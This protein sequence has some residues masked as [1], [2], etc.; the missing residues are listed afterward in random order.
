MGFQL[1]NW[2]FDPQNSKTHFSNWE[3]GSQL[4]PKKKKKKK[5]PNSEFEKLTLKDYMLY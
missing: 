2:V 3:F 5:A 1:E 4:F